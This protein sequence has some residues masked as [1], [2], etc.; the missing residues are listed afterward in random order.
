MERKKILEQEPIYIE[1]DRTRKERD[2]EKE[3]T[4]YSKKLRED[5]REVKIRYKKIEVY[6]IF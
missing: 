5:N 6:G 3:I 1:H 4:R 2:F